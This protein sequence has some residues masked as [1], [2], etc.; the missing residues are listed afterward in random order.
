M[1]DV[2]GW[3]DSVGLFSDAASWVCCSLLFVIIRCQWCPTG[4]QNNILKWSLIALRYQYLLIYLPAARHEKVLEST[5]KNFT[6]ALERPKTQRWNTA[7]KIP[8]C[9][10]TKKKVTLFRSILKS[11]V[12]WSSM[13]GNKALIN[14]IIYQ[15]IS[16]RERSSREIYGLNGIN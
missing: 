7:K 15:N 5:Q 16:W 14:Q 8:K 10:F 11:T 9:S 3:N 2:A 13:N 1:Q 12:L 4:K 6:L